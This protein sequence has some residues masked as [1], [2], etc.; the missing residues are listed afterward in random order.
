MFSSQGGAR[1]SAQML[2]EWLISQMMTIGRSKLHRRIVTARGVCLLNAG[3]IGYRF[4]N[5][6]NLGGDRAFVRKI[7]YN[8]NQQPL[9]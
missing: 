8:P 6:T 2:S 7:D 9:I 1:L 5:K 3:W 4:A